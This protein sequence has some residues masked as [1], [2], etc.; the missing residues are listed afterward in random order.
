MVSTYNGSTSIAKITKCIYTVLSAGMSVFLPRTHICHKESNMLRLLRGWLC[1]GKRNV[2]IGKGCVVTSMAKIDEGTTIE[3]YVRV[4]GH[5]TIGKNVY[6]N[7]FTMIS[8]EV[9]IGDGVLISQFVTIWGRAH[10]F[11]NR[12]LPIWDQHGKHGITDNGYDVQSVKIGTGVWIGPQVTVFRG[13]SI[14]DGAVIGAGS[15]VTHDVPAFAVCWGVP[16]RVVKYRQS[17][18]AAAQKA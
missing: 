12:D 14:G 13:V 1:S 4:V 5:I 16:A 15:V 17:E 18:Q 10:R 7:C 8:G 3:D 6:I 9:V 11:M 2:C